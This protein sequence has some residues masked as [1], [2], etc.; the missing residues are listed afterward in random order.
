MKR[1]P[2]VGIVILSGE[3]VLLVRHGEK[4]GHLTGSCGTPGGRIEEGETPIKA[5][6]RELEEETGLIV[7]EEDLIELPRKYD[8]NL[9][10]KDGSILYIHHTVFVSNRF[11]GTFRE[12]E[13]TIPEWISVKKLSEMT[14]LPNT[15][16]MVKQAQKTL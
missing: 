6:K 5:A 8:A 9:E 15:E 1:I 10:R 4:A 13:E 3:D 7:R 11:D 12:T 2:T 16:D 14:L